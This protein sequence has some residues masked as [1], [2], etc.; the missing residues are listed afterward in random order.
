MDIKK[1]LF[2]LQD[3]EFG[4]KSIK[5]VP[6]LAP[7]R[8]IGVRVPQLRKI[9]K[10]ISVLTDMR[11]DY[12]S[13]LPH[14]YHEENLLHGYLLERMKAPI[15]DILLEVERF[16]PFVNNWAVCDTMSP[17]LFAKYPKEVKAKCKEWMLSENVYTIRFA[18]VVHLQYFLDENFDESVFDEINRIKS[19]EYYVRMAIAWYYSFALIKQWEKTLPLIESKKL[20][21]WIHNKTIQKACES[22]RISSDRKQLLKSMRI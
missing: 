2:A 4:L 16:L 22:F 11:Q 6:G 18:V 17:K 5:F 10:K 21:K 14:Y 1:E 20:D 9:A 12:M 13:V 19:E 8:V 3:L 15:E 7:E